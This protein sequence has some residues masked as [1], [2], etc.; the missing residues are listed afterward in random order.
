MKE[1]VKL[2]IEFDEARD[3]YRE[4]DVSQQPAFEAGFL[5]AREMACSEVNR[6]FGVPGIRSSLEIVLQKLGEKEV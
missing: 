4:E 5:K 1:Y 2:A 3:V 6:Y